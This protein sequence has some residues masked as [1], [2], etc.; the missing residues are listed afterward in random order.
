MPFLDEHV[1][2]YTGDIAENPTQGCLGAQLL[3]SLTRLVLQ[4]LVSDKS[5]LVNGSTRGDSVH[6]TRN[7]AL[8]GAHLSLSSAQVNRYSKSRSHAWPIEEHIRNLESGEREKFCD[9]CT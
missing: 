5:A 4:L 1:D 2:F 3:F 8:C 9:V 7:I 6:G